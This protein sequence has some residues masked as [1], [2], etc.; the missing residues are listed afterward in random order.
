MMFAPVSAIIPCYNSESTLKRAVMS[1][2]QQTLRPAELIIIDNCS[3]D[4]TRD[5]ILELQ[6][7]LSKDWIRAVFNET[8]V[9]V[10]SSRNKAWDLASQPYI[11]LLDSDDFWHSRKIEI[12]YGYMSKHP[13]KIITG[14]GF[15][16][17]RGGGAERV[18]SDTFHVKQRLIK[19]LIR[20]NYFVTPSIMLKRDIPER[21]Q[22]G[23]NDMEDHL[24]LI[25]L[26]FQ[27]GPIDEIQLP[28]TYL[29]KAAIGEGGLASNHLQMERGELRNYRYLLSEGKIS[30]LFALALSLFSIAKFI[31]RIIILKILRKSI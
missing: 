2:Y 5:L 17:L 21:Y 11:A 20:K 26:C 1:V 13:N 8:N 7:R 6:N 28:L 25:E 23:R 27:Y 22:S 24:L 16:I 29:C 12:Q 9:G 3:S 4:G 15:E 30:A 31:R 19:Q 18:V 10:S 14:H